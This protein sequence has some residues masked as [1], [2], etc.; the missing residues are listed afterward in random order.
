M[1]KQTRDQLFHT[2][3]ET[4]FALD[5]AIQFL[6]T[7]PNNQE[8][9]DYYHHYQKKYK[10]ALNEYQECYGPINQKDVAEENY[11]T[12]VE[13]PWPWEGEC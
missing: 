5:E 10:K 4:S 3:T 12:W 9:L 1:K 2:V 8:A 6:D 11:W 13:T 7:H